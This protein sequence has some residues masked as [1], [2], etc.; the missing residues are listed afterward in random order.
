MH[1]YKIMEPE[2]PALLRQ[3]K[4]LPPH[5]YVAGNIP[6]DHHKFL[7]VVGSRTCSSYGKDVCK[8]LLEGLRGFPIVIISG[9]AIGIDSISHQVAL[10]NN[11]K[12]VAFPGSGLSERALYPSSRR[13]LARK[14][15]EREGALVSPFEM[16]QDG[17][18]WTFPVRN[19]L[20]A[21]CSHATLIIEGRPGS[22]TF[23]TGDCALEFNREV[24][25]VP[26]S[27]FS[28]LSYSP[29]DYWK[30][31]ARPVTCPTD[32]LQ[33]LKLEVPLDVIGKTLRNIEEN[34]F[35]TQERKIIDLLLER[36]MNAT[37]LIEKSG[38]SVS[39]F[40]MLITELELRD[41]LIQE[42][43]YYR[44]KVSSI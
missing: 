24:L 11:L 14:I 32:I 31:G 44:L 5:L 17:A 42:N 43:G 26:G 36:P 19:S 13:E 8:Y 15:I 23:I 40:N 2:Y 34:A 38:L 41:A 35:S 18:Y 9:L 7:C 20:M 27:I 16:D 33:A 37:D 25:I 39:S 29:H 22:G 4:K 1:V 28:E 3:L 30:E 21:A 6:N 10:E 12:T